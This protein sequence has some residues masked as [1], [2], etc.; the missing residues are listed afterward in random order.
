MSKDSHAFFTLQKAKTNYFTAILRERDWAKISVFVGFILIAASLALG[1]YFYTKFA[2]LFLKSYPEFT[3]TLL[4]YMLLTFFFLIFILTLGSSLISAI[5]ILFVS[6]DD[7]FLL[8]TPVKNIVI[9]ASR[10]VNLLAIASWPVLVFGTPFLIAFNQSFNLGIVNFGLSFFALLV[11][12]AISALAATLLAVKFTGF[13]GQNLK[14]K[15]KLLGFI[16]LP[17]L[18][19]WTIDILIPPGLI[20]SF[21]KLELYQIRQYLTSIPLNSNLLPSTWAVNFIINWQTNPSLALTNYASLLLLMLVLSLLVYFLIKKEYFTN[22][23]KAKVGRFIAG[24]HDIVGEEKSVMKFPY[25]FKGIKGAFLK[26]DILVISRNQ[27]EILQAAFILFLILLYFLA[28]A[29][30]PPAH[31][32]K[33]LPGLSIIYLIRINFAVVSFVLSV[34]AL[35][36]LYPSISLEGHASWFIWPAPFSKTKIYWQKF[37]TGWTILSFVAILASIASSLI[38]K[39]NFALFASQVSILVATSL[40]LTSINLGLGTLFPDFEEKNAEKIS[41]SKGGIA[42][43]FASLVFILSIYLLVFSKAEN[44]SFLTLPNLYT[45]LVSVIIA[46]LFSHLALKKINNYRF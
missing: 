16:S 2:L 5:G 31:I 36:F 25:F 15:Y 28:L 13:A 34:F 12:V 22:L 21:Q 6:D 24:E 18:A 45:W 11:I 39:L 33:A 44:I 37:V 29:K 9:F 32:E 8:A 43:T 1:T 19:A 23:A 20:E 30:V 7:D 4:L 17:F 38:L 41:T 40:A 3:D 26:K 46:S 10:F 14:R 42:A 27:T 35:R